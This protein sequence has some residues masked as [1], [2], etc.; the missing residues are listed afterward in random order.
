MFV[1]KLYTDKEFYKEYPTIYHLRN[2]LFSDSTSHD[3]RL[4]YLALHHIIKHRGHFVYEGQDFSTVM[5]FESIFRDAINT[6][7][8]YGIDYGIIDSQVDSIKEIIKNKEYNLTTKK[9]EIVKL[10]RI[11]KEDEN[12]NQKKA[13]AELIVGSSVKISAI[14]DDKSFDEE[15]VNK[16]CF[17][18]G[19]EEDKLEAVLKENMYLIEKLKSIY[20]WGVLSNI[21]QDSENLSF[22]KERIF[23]EHKQ[24]LKILVRMPVKLIHIPCLQ[25][26]P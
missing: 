13:I 26:M 25:C 5:D 20:D 6:L 2:K 9:K 7:S 22:A 8:D 1:D 11:D 23:E 3:I 17:S 15:E 21:L 19:I 10:M 18:D 16:I 14:F 4:V 24:D 12:Y